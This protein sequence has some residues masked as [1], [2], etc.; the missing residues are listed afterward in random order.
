MCTADTGEVFASNKKDRVL[1][2]DRV[3]PVIND[4][5][6]SFMRGIRQDKDISIMI[7]VKNDVSPK[8]DDL[9]F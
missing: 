4:W 7:T 5:L 9:F 1:P 8:M 3:E 6:K 2:I